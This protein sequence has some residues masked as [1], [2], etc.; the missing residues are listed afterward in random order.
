[1]IFENA[2]IST[3]CSDG[4]M[5]YEVPG[6]FTHHSLKDVFLN[7]VRY[8]PFGHV[9]VCDHCLNFILCLFHT[10]LLEHFWFV[11]CT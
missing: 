8:S 1:M 2:K 7:L 11:V 5:S 10:L 9:Q 4:P 3:D 6:V